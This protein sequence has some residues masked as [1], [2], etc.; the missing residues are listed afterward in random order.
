L[1]FNGVTRV[2]S[3]IWPFAAMVYLVLLAAARDR[4]EK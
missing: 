1:N 3:T 4:P 2:V